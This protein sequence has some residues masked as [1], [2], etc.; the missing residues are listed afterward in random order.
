MHLNGGEFISFIEG[1]LIYLWLDLEKVNSK[2]LFRYRQRVI[3]VPTKGVGSER[4]IDQVA[5][6]TSIR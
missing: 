2:C 3:Q 6:A 4:Y 1:I 5:N